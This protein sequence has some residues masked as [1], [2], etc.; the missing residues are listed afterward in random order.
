MAIEIQQGTPG[1]GKSAVAVAR[2]VA[3]LQEGG[4]VAANFSL[5]DGWPET[6]AKRSL[7]GRFSETIRHE[8]AAELHKRF[9][10]VDSLKAIKGID[11][12]EM[13]VGRHKTI[14]GKFQEG[15]GLL[16]LDEVQL[17]F[18]SRKWEKNF[19]WIEFFTQHRKL[20][21]NIILIA[22][23]IQMVDSQIRP[24]IELES[25]F[26]N[27]QKVRIPVVGLPFSPIP[28]FLV[29]RRYAG[30]GA[31]ASVIHSRSMYPLPLWAARL[32]DSCHV[33]SAESWGKEKAAQLCG[34]APVSPEF[35]KVPSPLRRSSLAG[36]HWDD[37]VMTHEPVSSH[38]L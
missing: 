17:I 16:L 7:L 6:V 31:G 27:M 24:L 15:Q 3:H 25:R 36:P 21:W 4:V 34:P 11:P 32:Y 33:F 18:N 29:I 28:L 23:D 14:K 19:E 13:A 5:V 2:A 20:G 30:L 12:K 8:R 38:A 37:Y 10:R 22:H 9:L 35:V 26:R 1:S